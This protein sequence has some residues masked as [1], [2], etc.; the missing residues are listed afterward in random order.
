MKIIVSMY[1]TLL[2]MIIAGCLNMLFCKKNICSVLCKP[3]DNG[4]VL[5]DGR[6]L[7]GKNKTWKGFIGYIIF[8]I[9]TS[10]L[11]GLLFN[12]MNWNRYSFFY[13]NNDN[14]LMFNIFIGFLLG[15]AYA[16]FELPNSFIKRRCDID[17]GEKANGLKKYLFIILDQIDSIIGCIIIV[18]IFY[19]MSVLFFIGYVALGGF[20][21]FI[22]NLIL[23]SLK[24]RK[25]LC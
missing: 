6:R 13:L 5:K 11:F 19:K 22:L 1:V 4:L 2:S 17:S 21:H 18:S 15:F 9:L 10:V 8:S 14:T 25:T 24:L 12:F 3:I 20:T 7:F 16:I 23:Y